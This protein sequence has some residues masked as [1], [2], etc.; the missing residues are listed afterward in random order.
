MFDWTVDTLEAYM[1]LNKKQT[2]LTNGFSKK[3]SRW[4][5]CFT[6]GFLPWH[7]LQWRVW[8]Q[9]LESSD[10]YKPRTSGIGLVF[11]T[12]E[13]KNHQLKKQKHWSFDTG[14]QLYGHK[15]FALDFFSMDWQHQWALNEESKQSLDRT[16]GLWVWSTG[17][18]KQTKWSKHWLLLVWSMDEG[19]RQSPQQTHW[20]LVVWSSDEGNQTETEPAAT[21]DLC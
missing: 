3:R 21:T 12:G 9:E 14:R 1:S 18:G 13:Q 20:P 4:T 7:C 6:Q 17:W 19:E 8:G 16:T 15:C 10:R 11:L 2:C 5:D